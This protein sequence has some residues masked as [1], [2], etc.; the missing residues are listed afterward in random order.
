[1]K[2]KI[3]KFYVNTQQ[4]RNQMRYVR[5]F[6]LSAQHYD[7]NTDQHREELVKGPLQILFF[8]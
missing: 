3:D 7:M 4:I 1:M 5:L 2:E 8:L 6:V